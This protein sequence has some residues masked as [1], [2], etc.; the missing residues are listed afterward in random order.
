VKKIFMLM[1]PVLFVPAFAQGPVE[2][3]VKGVS[4]PMQLARDGKILSLNG[5]GVRT[6]VVFKVYACGLYVENLSASAEELVS[7]DQV[8]FI[9]LVFLRNVDGASVADAINGGFD[10]NSKEQLPALRERLD[11]FRKL[12]PNLKKG[13]RLAFAYTPAGKGVTVEVN[14]RK[15]GEIAGKDFADALFRCW[16]GGS[17]ADKDL[18][19]G[20]LG[21]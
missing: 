6:K 11:K 9:E 3:T 21:E 1:L 18:K 15:A 14:G 19:K 10:K 13:S 4:F 20:L 5:L 8:K 12:I 16:L 17:P 7:S 2:R